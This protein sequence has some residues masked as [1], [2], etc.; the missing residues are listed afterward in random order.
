MSHSA[1]RARPLRELLAVQRLE[2][3]RLHLERLL[4]CLCSICRTTGFTWNG[5]GPGLAAIIRVPLEVI[6]AACANCTLL[7]SCSPPP[8]LH[9][10][11]QPTQNPA[12]TLQGLAPMPAVIRLLQPRRPLALTAQALRPLPPVGRGAR[13]RG[14]DLGHLDPHHHRARRVGH[15]IRI[16]GAIGVGRVDGLLHLAHRHTVAEDELELHTLGD[17]AWGAHEQPADARRHEVAL[18][19]GILL[20]DDELDRIPRPVLAHD[21]AIGGVRQP[22]ARVLQREIHEQLCNAEVG[23]HRAQVAHTVRATA[24]HLYYAQQGSAIPLHVR[25][26]R[27][28]QQLRLHRQGGRRP[29][30]FLGLFAQLLWDA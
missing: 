15:D 19:S 2:H 5:A 29:L 22:H 12:P 28:V 11:R 26:L 27:D 6:H 25:E 17:A 21:H 8:P 13:D 18:L 23:S 14:H 10:L 7:A 16:D 24:S 3:V 30:C 4:R 9:Q 1:M 20:A